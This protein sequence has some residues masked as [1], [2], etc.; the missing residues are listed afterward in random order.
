[1]S[2]RR[3]AG[4][5]CADTVRMRLALKP[6]MVKAGQRPNTSGNS[7]NR[8]SEQKMMRKRWN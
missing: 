8:L 1:M 5:D 4:K 6:T 3:L 2:Q 7:V